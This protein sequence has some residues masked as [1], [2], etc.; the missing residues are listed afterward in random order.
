MAVPI[1]EGIAH[2]VLAETGK[3]EE[4]FQRSATHFLCMAVRAALERSRQYLTETHWSDAL[5]IQGKSAKLNDEEGMIREIRTIHVEAPP[6]TVFHEFL[7]LGGD[8]GWLRWMWAWKIRGAIDRILGGP[9]L[10]RGRRNPH[11]A[12]PGESIDF[13]RVEAV[14]APHLLRL[15][16]ELKVPGNAWVEFGRRIRRNL[17]AN[18][19]QTAFFWPKGLGGYLYWYALYPIHAVIFGSLVRAIAKEAEAALLKDLSTGEI[20]SHSKYFQPFKAQKFHS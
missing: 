19:V 12:Y 6:E 5:R 10:R 13:W 18:L 7:S 4:Q 20:R 8:R 17:E 16:A 9:G 3:A 15:R 1:I 11:E 14:E 2:A